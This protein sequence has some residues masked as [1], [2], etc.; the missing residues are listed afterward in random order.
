[1]VAEM[2]EHIVEEEGGDTIT[3]KRFQQMI[4]KHTPPSLMDRIDTS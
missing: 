2:A 4:D 3:H 1:M